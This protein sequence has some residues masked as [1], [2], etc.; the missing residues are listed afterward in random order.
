VVL[1]VIKLIDP[2]D[3]VLIHAG[4]P[5]YTV[6][7]AGGAEVIRKVGPWLGLVAAAGITVGALTSRRA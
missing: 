5:D 6:S 1:I 2:P 7:Q 3:L 4:V